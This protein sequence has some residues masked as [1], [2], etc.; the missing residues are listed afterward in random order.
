M[1]PVRKRSRMGRLN[2]V[3]AASAL[4]A[5]TGAAFFT[6]HD[7]MPLPPLHLSAADANG[8]LTLK[9][10]RD[11]L[12]DIDHATLTLNDGGQAHTILLDRKQLDSGSTQYE[13]KSA[14][15]DALLRA[16][17]TTAQASYPE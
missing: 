1:P 11:G 5:G 2:W 6:R 10:N 17:D 12:P 14:H 15:V 8:H 13:R 7:W 16:G 4:V 9:W 3:L